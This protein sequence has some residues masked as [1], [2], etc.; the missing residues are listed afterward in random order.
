LPKY[1]ARRRAIIAVLTEAREQAGL[2]QRELSAKLDEAT[3]YVHEIENG[4]HRVR[5]EEFVAIAEALGI[6][7]LELLSRVL[8]RKT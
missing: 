4:Q 6:D 2:S 1:A 8:K 5:T 7:P 3:T